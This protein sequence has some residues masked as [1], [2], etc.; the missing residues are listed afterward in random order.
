MRRSPGYAILFSF[1]IL[2]SIYST[3][4]TE[5]LPEPLNLA[6][7]LAQAPSHPE[8]A[9]SLAELDIAKAGLIVSDSS[10]D[11]SVSL[12][13]RLQWI[14]P[15][16][17]SSNQDHDDHKISLNAEKTL[18][19]FGRR[20]VKNNAAQNQISSSLY[21]L[22]YQMGS[23]RI[24]IMQRYFNVLL[25][26]LEFAA[27]NEAIAT[28]FIRVDRLRDR[29][30]FGEVSELEVLEAESD[31]QQSLGKRNRSELKQR[32]TRALLAAAI[33]QPSR[34]S[35][36]LLEPELSQIDREIPEYAELLK[37]SMQYN[38][39]L[40]ALNARLE[41][42]VQEQDLARR[43]FHPAL[44]AYGEIAE[45][46]REEGGSDQ[47]RLGV[48][49]KVP[50]WQ[51]GRKDALLAIEVAQSKKVESELRLLQAEVRQLLLEIWQQLSLQKQQV[52]QAEV[53][54]DA[55]D[56]YLDRSRAL[57]ELD[58]RSDLGDAMIRFSRSRLKHA[59]ARYALA[60]SWEHL[61]LLT[62]GRILAHPPSESAVEATSQ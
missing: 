34:L 17:L 60:I 16:H 7:A 62:G 11:F 49:I 59:S 3:V 23:K 50:L 1:L 41:A 4:Y 24:E 55:R 53:E 25:A 57:Y 14:G 61:D 39:S 13:G 8:V 45:Y 33:N 15:S 43:R 2:S 56:L 51:G 29:L 6:F 58:V 37:T 28:A 9:A 5:E 18:Y 19:D 10:N 22:E 54:L 44:S 47:W 48:K 20:R 35:E 21:T 38:P 30:E 31:Y 36:D 32:S 12:N 27:E 42:A 26:D 46:S 40:K 52:A